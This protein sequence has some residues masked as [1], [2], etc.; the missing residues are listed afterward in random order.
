MLI[1]CESC[2]VEQHK[3]EFSLM[4]GGRVYK[5]CKSCK[6]A[7]M[8]ERLEKRDK[9]KGD[10]SLID[11]RHLGSEAKAKEH[12]TAQ[13]LKAENDAKESKLIIGYRVTVDKY[14]IKTYIQY[15]K[16]RPGSS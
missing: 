15:S 13:K 10:N 1:K 16:K 5:R 6:G 8:Q 11:R 2:G 4:P 3:K 7:R 9:I 14:G 12:Q